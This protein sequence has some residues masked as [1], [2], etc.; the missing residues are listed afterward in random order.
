MLENRFINNTFIQA[1]IQGRVTFSI[2]KPDAVRAHHVG[3]IIS[4]IEKAGFTIKAMSMTHLKETEAQDFYKVHANRPFYKD[5]CLFMASGPIVVMV[6]EKDNAIP[7][8]RKLMGTTNPLD[9]EEG[10]IRKMFARSIDENAIHG[11][12]GY[13][14]AAEEIAFFFPS[15]YIK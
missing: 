5:L 15:N 10:T 2:I 1:I 7:N 13:E 6:L 12:D 14:T 4:M 11:S 8:F 9:A 3:T